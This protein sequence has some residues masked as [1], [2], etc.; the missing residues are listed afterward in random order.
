MNRPVV[1]TGDAVLFVLDDEGVA[2]I[3]PRQELYVFNMAATFVW[4][5]IEE[6]LTPEAIVDA[7]A[8]AFGLERGRAHDDVAD[9]LNRWWSLGYIE[10]PGIPPSTPITLVTALGRLL[11]N[12]SLRARFARSPEDVAQSMRVR[13]ADRATFLA[14]D[15]QELDAEAER[16]RPGADHRH[17][18][19]S[20]TDTFFSGYIDGQTALS[21]YAARCRL[22]GMTQPV[23]E[24]HYRLLDTTFLLRFGSAVAAAS[25]RPA[26]AQ[27]AAEG[28]GHPDVQFEVVEG[29]R[30]FVIVDGCLPVSHCRGLD[31]LT[32]ILKALLRQRALDRAQ[33]FLELHAGVVSDGTHC[34]VLPAAP[35]SGK[36]TLTAGLVCAGFEYFSDEVA[37]LDEVSLRLRPVPL[38]LGVKPGAVDVLAGLFPAV[39][40]LPVHVREDGQ[41]VRYLSLRPEQM[42]PADCRREARWLVFPRYRAGAD[43]ALRPIS[44]PDALRRLMHECMVLPE[45]LSEARVEQLVGWMRHLDCYDLSISSLA[46]AVRLL[47]AN[48]RP[49]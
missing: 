2:F 47:E 16:I 20:G 17:R 32:P 27:M 38:G 41:S 45:L 8:A 42:A 10:D 9:L 7:Y 15:P 6:R 44:R 36:T 31:E 29:E 24:Q 23:V 48:C 3:A 12:A 25:V 49:R 4:C 18:A 14:L 21:T 35:G 30:G 39:R 26:L 40:C 19:H 37:L 22:R 5:C 1:P 46:D 28:A 34:L 13:D 33:F 43:T 11:S